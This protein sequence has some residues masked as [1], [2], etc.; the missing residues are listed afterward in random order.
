MLALVSESD[1]LAFPEDT[2]LC[3]RQK[4]CELLGWKVPWKA[5]RNANGNMSERER[6]KE[7]RRDQ[8]PCLNIKM[9]GGRSREKK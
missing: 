4:V 2:G 8:E 5:L 3:E 7:R 9:Q 6:E 1:A